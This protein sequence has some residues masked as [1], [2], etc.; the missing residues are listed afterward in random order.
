M[1]VGNYRGEPVGRKVPTLESRLGDQITPMPNGCWIFG[2]GKVNRPKAIYKFGNRWRVDWML[3]F[4]VHPS[5]PRRRDNI[6]WKLDR[7]CG[8]FAC[9]NPH[10]HKL[11]KADLTCKH[12]GG[13]QRWGLKGRF[14]SPKC[15]NAYMAEDHMAMVEAARNAL[16][17]P[18]ATGWLH[19]LFAYLADRDGE[20]CSLC[21]EPIDLQ[22]KDTR[23]GPSVDHVLPRSRGGSHELTNLAL[24]H[25][26][27][28]SRKG[29]R[30]A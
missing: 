2:T 16:D 29:N 9:V 26:S 6:R 4:I 25:R 1:V 10:H 21:D 18:A 19:K 27:C 24:A 22:S 28:N 5:D 3:W 7:Q 8:T 23:W 15:A 13:Y 11:I 30:V 17:L 20:Q 14:C 12:C